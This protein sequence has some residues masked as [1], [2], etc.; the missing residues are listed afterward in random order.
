MIKVN[1]EGKQVTNGE[2][3]N[4]YNVT[5]GLSG[6]TVTFDRETY[7]KYPSKLIFE[8]TSYNEKIVK[9]YDSANNVIDSK[10]T[11]TRT[12]LPVTIDGIDFGKRHE[13]DDIENNKK[14]ITFDSI[15]LKGIPGKRTWK[16]TISNSYE[17][18][19]FYLV[20]QLTT[21]TTTDYNLSIAKD[22]EHST[23]FQNNTI[24]FQYLENL[25]SPITSYFNVRSNRIDTT[26]F[27]PDKED[28]VKKLYYSSPIQLKEKLPISL[29]STINVDVAT[30]S[31]KGK[32]DGDFYFRVN[33]KEVATNVN[34]Q[35]KNETISI[36]QSDP[37]STAKEVKFTIIQKGQQSEIIEDFGDNPE[38]AEQVF[39][40]YMLYHV[41]GTAYSSVTSSYNWNDEESK[42]FDVYSNIDTTL[43]NPMQVEKLFWFTENPDKF[44]FKGSDWINFY[45]HQNKVND[46]ESTYIAFKIKNFKINVCPSY[47]KVL[48]DTNS[49]DYKWASYEVPINIELLNAYSDLVSITKEQTEGDS[50]THNYDIHVMP[51]AWTDQENGLTGS[52]FYYK[53]P[54]EYFTTIKEK[55]KLKTAITSPNKDSYSIWTDTELAGCDQI[56]LKTTIED[57]PIKIVGIKWYSNTSFKNCLAYNPLTMCIPI[58]WNQQ[59]QYNKA[60]DYYNKHYDESSKGYLG[61]EDHNGIS[62]RPE[63]KDAN[64]S[65]MPES[66]QKAIK[67]VEDVD[68][69][70]N[71]KDNDNKNNNQQ[72]SLNNDLGVQDV[73]PSSS[74][75]LK[76]T[77]SG[78]DGSKITGLTDIGNCIAECDTDK[79]ITSLS[80]DITVSD[81]MKKLEEAKNNIGE[82]KK[83]ATKDDVPEYKIA[84]I[85]VYGFYDGDESTKYFAGGAASGKKVTSI[86]E[87][88]GVKFDPYW[89]MDSDGI[90]GNYAFNGLSISLNIHA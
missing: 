12:W 88:D 14:T 74:T 83:Y 6:G 29:S 18:F 70:D 27:D 26:Y 66:A 58:T 2:V 22:E 45:S 8:I 30:N 57:M 25:T 69:K 5:F 56:Q 11:I 31:T 15:D 33:C 62:I 67:E 79:G 72:N 82:G 10:T 60:L 78:F 39:T 36:V 52:E 19:T 35:E 23:N 87:G 13:I 54:D 71:D 44:E 9:T 7:I 4:L 46:K 77:I 28:N 90:S 61:P 85:T 40:S 16:V 48:A 59:M 84:T 68:N 37:K 3:I 86:F 43:A 49:D 17:V 1:F 47:Y 89:T 64:L 41:T 34:A 53:R 24:T 81:K 63:N 55:S 51:K 38:A 75:Q 42:V 21:Y 32:N 73:P 80:V 76:M 20:G 65:Y 50:N